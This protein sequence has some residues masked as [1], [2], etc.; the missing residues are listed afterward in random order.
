MDSTRKEDAI[1]YKRVAYQSLAIEEAQKLWQEIEFE[2]QCD[3][4]SKTVRISLR[5]SL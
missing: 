5:I 3:G 2:S 1:L 4:D